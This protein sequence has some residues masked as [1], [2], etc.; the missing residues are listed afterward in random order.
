[1]PHNTGPPALHHYTGPLPL[2]LSLSLSLTFYGP[3]NG[4][5]AEA[6]VQ[7]SSSYRPVVIINRQDPESSREKHLATAHERVASLLH[8]NTI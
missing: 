8:S 5:F 6:C 7:K 1:M 4:R 3:L 2:S